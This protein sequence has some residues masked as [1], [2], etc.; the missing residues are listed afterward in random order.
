MNYIA[1]IPSCR[2]GQ[3]IT[4]L[5]FLALSS[6]MARSEPG[7]TDVIDDYLKAQTQGLPGKVSHSIG[8]LDP[9]TQLAPCTAYD[10]FTPQ[11]GRLWGKATVGVRCLGPSSWTIYVPVQIRVQGN[12]LITTRPLPP[13]T[14]LRPEDFAVRGGDLTTKP[15]GV[16]TD[17]A[18]AIGKS[19][20]NGLG[21]GQPLRSDQLVAPMAILQ[22]QT[23]KT[24]SGG[25]GFSVSSE[26]KALNNAAVGQIVQVRSANGQ[27]ISGIA[28]PGGIVEISN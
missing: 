24:V 16:L 27:T 2:T 23:V 4:L 7:L 17:P 8:P 21:S 18:Q 12:Y 5:L 10:P 20:K 14:V 25:S 15:S 6:C 11:G 3:I 22:G 13:G 19:V 28:R 9:R 1:P 26:G